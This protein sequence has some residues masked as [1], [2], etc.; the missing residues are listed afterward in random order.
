[1]KLLLVFALGLLV[2][3]CIQPTPPQLDVWPPAG[4]PQDYDAPS[5]WTDRW[6]IAADPYGGAAE[7][8]TPSGGSVTAPYFEI[9]GFIHEGKTEFTFILGRDVD[10]WTEELRIGSP[11]YFGATFSPSEA[12]FGIAGAFPY[13]R[14]S[15]G[16]S[17][18]I[19][20]FLKDLE[21]LNKPAVF[22]SAN[23]EH[24][25]YFY[26]RGLSAHLERFESCWEPLAE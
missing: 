26:L 15:S 13:M 6:A 23:G 12:V 20:K 7:L 14:F 22:S 5:H 21:A 19:V 18:R 3:A 16:D 2:A 10:N 1:M 25:S 11:E 17:E 8:Q 4:C 9:V 24:R